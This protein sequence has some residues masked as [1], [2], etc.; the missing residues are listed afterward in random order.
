MTAS[1]ASVPRPPGG[2]IHRSIA[3]LRSAFDELGVGVDLGEV[4]RLAVMVNRAMTAEARSFHT[5]EHIFGLVDPGN[6][7]ITL[8]ALFHDIVYYNVDQGF[9]P[10]IR[11]TLDPCFQ[12]RDGELWLRGPAD[13]EDPALALCRGVFGAAAGQKLSAAA[14]MNELLS[15]LVMNR[16][17]WGVV[18]AADLLV[19]TGCIEATIPFRKPDAS[20]RTPADLLLERLTLTAR[21]MSLH[22]D[23]ERLERAVGWAVTFANRDVSNFGERE[24]TRF[25]DNTWKLLP[26]SNPS[27]RLQGVY[28]IASYRA[29]LQKMEGFLRSLDPRMVFAQFRGVPG[30]AEYRELTERAGRNL[31]AARGYLGIKLLTAAILEALAELTGGDAP[32]SLFMGDLDARTPGDRLDDHLPPY[33]P[34]PGLAVDPGL[35]DLLAL[36]RASASRFDLQNS[37][38]SL[39]IYLN[40]GAEETPRALDGARAMFGG[41]TGPA[42]FLAGLPAAVVGAVARAC[43]RMAFTRAAELEA[44]AA[45][46]GA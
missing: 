5:P 25:L 34:P 36:G 13:G 38:L 9:I 41:A 26:E 44:I 18:P 32:V 1:S 4:E 43:A 37:P 12:A 16:R 45:G 33:A 14:G 39:F 28:S 19:A 35:R 7:H 46:R 17:L 2:A 23:V 24:V 11:Q 10:E 3:L 8:A 27:L 20:G 31:A 29:A 22:L 30:D 40:L 6:P 15:A 42:A 21:A